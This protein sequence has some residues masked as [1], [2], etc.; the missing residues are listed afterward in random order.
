MQSMEILQYFILYAINGDIV[1]IFK[2]NNFNQ[3]PVLRGK[4]DHLERGETESR[5]CLGRLMSGSQ[6]VGHD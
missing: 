6:R 1:R 4:R 3:I 2:W 5:K